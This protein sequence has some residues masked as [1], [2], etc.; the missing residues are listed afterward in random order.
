MPPRAENHVAVGTRP[1]NGERQGIH[2]MTSSVL[3]DHHLQGQT[4]VTPFNQLNPVLQEVLWTDDIIPQILWIALL[5]EYNGYPKGQELAM[6]LSRAARLLTNTNSRK[7][8][9]AASE[10]ESISTDDWASIHKTI[11]A[12]GCLQRVVNA[13]T[14]LE[15]FCRE[16]PFSELLADEPA[17]PRVDAEKIVKSVVRRLLL[18]R[19]SWESTM[20]QYTVGRIAF[21]S[22]KVKVFAHLS[23]ANPEA[24]NEYP[25]T[26]KSRQIASNLRT[27]ASMLFGVSE[28]NLHV[29]SETWVRQFWEHCLLSTQCEY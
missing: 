7:A 16:T 23:L 26:E 15:S 9:Y 11:R 5:H 24:V 6:F 25:R 8:Y 20:V 2:Q 17:M 3:T 18:R 21:E 14:P 28:V 29:S 12:N 22:N 4:L 19:D 10:Y 1:S 13:L 27:L